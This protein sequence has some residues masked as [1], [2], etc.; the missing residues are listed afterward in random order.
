[1]KRLAEKGRERNKDSICQD[2]RNVRHNIERLGYHF[3][4]AKTLAAAPSILPHLFDD[5][6]VQCLPTP[7]NLNHLHTRMRRQH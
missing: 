5:F 2:F 3:R 7:L 4:V 6:E 1:M